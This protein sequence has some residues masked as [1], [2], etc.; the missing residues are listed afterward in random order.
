[1]LRINSSAVKPPLRQAPK[2]YAAFY[3]D[4]EKQQTDRNK[5]KLWQTLKVK[6]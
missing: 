6:K 1:V 4:R 5:N 3:D 2:R